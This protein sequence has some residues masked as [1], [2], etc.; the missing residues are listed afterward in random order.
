MPYFMCRFG[1]VSYPGGLGV[2]LR[3][4]PIGQVLPSHRGVSA[5]FCMLRFNVGYPGG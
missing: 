4:A 2:G 1:Y 3:G 5:L